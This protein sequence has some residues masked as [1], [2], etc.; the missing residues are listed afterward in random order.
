MG[1]DN[2]NV[3]WRA[4]FNAKGAVNR[5]PGL[6]AET[7]ENSSQIKMT[8]KYAKSQNPTDL[9]FSNVLHAQINIANMLKFTSVNK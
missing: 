9:K 3:E 7:S 8:Q 4:K 5:Q 1:R 6:R 2:Q